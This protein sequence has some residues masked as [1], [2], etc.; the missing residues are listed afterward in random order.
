MC[1]NWWDI[2]YKTR[3]VLEVSAILRDENQREV[4]RKIIT[5]HRWLRNYPQTTKLKGSLRIQRS[6]LPDVWNM[7]K[8]EKIKRVQF[9]CKLSCPLNVPTV[10]RL[11]AD[12][13]ELQRQLVC[14]VYVSNTTYTG[15]FFAWQY[16]CYLLI[17]RTV[18]YAPKKKERKKALMW[19][20]R[21][22]DVP[23]SSI[24]D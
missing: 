14:L 18:L 13:Q 22:S 21:P 10:H 23:L 7:Q 12:R 4:Y 11:R 24:S 20:P 2:W 3:S 6:P 1:S 17:V 16:I 8:H 9:M 19:R 5:P 15:Y